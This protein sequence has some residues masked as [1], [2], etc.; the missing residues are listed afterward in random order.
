MSHSIEVYC[1]HRMIWVEGFAQILP[2]DKKSGM[3]IWECCELEFDRRE[4]C[5]LIEAASTHLLQKRKRWGT[6][7]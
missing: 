7:V 4:S 1:R 5:S 3:T 6:L 2:L